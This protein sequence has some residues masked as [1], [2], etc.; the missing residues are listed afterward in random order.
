MNWISSAPGRICLFGEHQDYLGLDI[1]AGAINLRFRIQCIP[2]TDRLYYLKM[3]DI[4]Q[5]IKFIPSEEV[6]YDNKRD[7]LKAT[8][9]ILKR[10]Y[11]FDFKKGYDFIF[12]SEIPIN[13]DA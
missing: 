10:E 8:V 1:I 4:N 3:P 7:Y 13:A 11:G 6:K 9:N 12:K 2:G 5:E